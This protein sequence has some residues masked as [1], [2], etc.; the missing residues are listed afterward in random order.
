MKKNLQD[1][2]DDILYGQRF[3]RKP[4]IP[5]TI[6]E[7]WLWSHHIN[8]AF[9]FTFHDDSYAEINDK[10]YDFVL[11]YNNII[12]CIIEYDGGQHS[13]PVEKFE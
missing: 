8:Y 13:A 2:I 1:A 12:M 11:F 5:E 3:P 6:I 7:K 9:E 10:R 4:S